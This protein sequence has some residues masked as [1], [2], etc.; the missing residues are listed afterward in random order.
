MLFHP[1]FPLYWSY[2]CTTDILKHPS[3][4]LCR[5]LAEMTWTTGLGEDR[6][7]SP[8]RNRITF[9]RILTFHYCRD[10][11]KGSEWKNCW[12]GMG[13]LSLQGVSIISNLPFMPVHAI[14]WNVCSF[15]KHQADLSG[16]SLRLGVNSLNCLQNYAY[17]ERKLT[18]LVGQ[19][20]GNDVKHPN[21]IQASGQM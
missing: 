2:F 1:R 10:W 13:K 6:M 19:Q 7:V 5:C 12:L 21:Q 15:L 20:L 18:R 16:T 14:Y 11:S 8:A 4:I 17:I 3:Q 9:S